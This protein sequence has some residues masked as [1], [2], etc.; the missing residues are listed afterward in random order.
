MAQLNFHKNL[1]S[2]APPRLFPL[3]QKT[4]EA[5]SLWYEYYQI[6]RK[7]HRHSLGQR[8]DNLLIEIIELIAT[9]GFLPQEKKLPYIQL[10]IRKND[11]LKILLMIL[12]ENKSLDNKKYMALSI[13]LD[14]MGKML[15]GWLG[16]L[17]KQNSPDKTS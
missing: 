13:K 17:Q 8:I 15:G 10:A 14:E 11:T 4:K 16:Q 2:N 6:L 9:A 3:L 1:P 12:W 7:P 5:Y